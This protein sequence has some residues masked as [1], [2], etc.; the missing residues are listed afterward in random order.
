MDDFVKAAGIALVAVILSLILA[1][2]NKDISTL[3]IIAVCAII[4]IS[5]MQY[6][7]PIIDFFRKL[8]V[9]GQLDSELF[10]ILLKAVGIGLLSEIAGMICCDSGNAALAKTLQ[11]LATAVI[12]WISLPMLNNLLQ[13]IENVLE[14]V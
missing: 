6:L 1:K 4:V 11:I 8:K 12:I 9:I 7:H 3:L 5:A 13:L 10:G 14:A 2:Q